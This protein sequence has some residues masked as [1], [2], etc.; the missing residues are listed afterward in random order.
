MEQA[1][2]AILLLLAAIMLVQ[3]LHGGPTQLRQW[4]GSKFL[5]KNS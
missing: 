4:V 2:G 1:A 5:G 3:L